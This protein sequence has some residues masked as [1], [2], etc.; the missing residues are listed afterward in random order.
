MLRAGDIEGLESLFKAYYGP[1][2]VL[3]LILLNLKSE[4]WGEHKL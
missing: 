4:M 1:Q 3:S 2:R